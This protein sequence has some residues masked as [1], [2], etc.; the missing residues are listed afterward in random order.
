MSCQHCGERGSQ[1]LGPLQFLGCDAPECVEQLG[2]R[3]SHYG[4]EHYLIHEATPFGR[5]LS[6]RPVFVAKRDGEWLVVGRK[7]AHALAPTLVTV[8]QDPSRKRRPGVEDDA[9]D[10]P[11]SPRHKGTAE[12]A[13]AAAPYVPL[14]ARRKHPVGTPAA[15]PR[16]PLSARRKYRPLKGHGPLTQGARESFLAVPKDV[17]AITFP[18][19]SREHREAMDTSTASVASRPD[20]QAAE[21]RKT[22]T[23]REACALYVSPIDAIKVQALRM[24]WPNIA[25]SALG[26]MLLMDE[27]VWPPDRLIDSTWTDA[28]ERLEAEVGDLGPAVVTFADGTTEVP[29]SLSALLQCGMWRRNPALILDAAEM[30]THL[31]NVPYESPETYDFLGFLLDQSR[32]WGASPP[33]GLPNLVRRPG[34]FAPSLEERGVDLARINQ[35]DGRSVAHTLALLVTNRV[36]NAQSALQ[37]LQ[38]TAQ[39]DLTGVVQLDPT[40]FDS[41]I[42][43][44]IHWPVDMFASVLRIMRERGVFRGVLVH[45]L[46]QEG[47]TVLHLRVDSLAELRGYAQ[48]LIDRAQEIAPVTFGSDVPVVVQNWRGEPPLLALAAADAI[49]Q[50]REIIGRGHVNAWRPLAVDGDGYT[51]GTF[52]A[53]YRFRDLRVRDRYERTKAL[54]NLLVALGG[55]VDAP[56]SPKMLSK[57]MAGVER[58][59]QDERREILRVLKVFWSVMPSASP[60]PPGAYAELWEPMIKLAF[61]EGDFA[62]VGTELLRAFPVVATTFHR[63]LYA[64]IDGNLA[65]Y[66]VRHTL[67]RQ[68]PKDARALIREVARLAPATM[69]EEDKARKQPWEYD[70]KDK[71]GVQLFTEEGWVSMGVDPPA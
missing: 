17:W 8:G 57:L 59:R 63:P 25:R 38:F 32:V 2:T 43:L 26:F 68:R 10:E 15:A 20:V 44:T 54:G 67:A 9:E 58:E 46:D 35:I 71:N 65:H 51:V 61:G 62:W 52:L 33:I 29:M 34:S 27:V 5:A 70:T 41:L 11:E 13:A 37:Q 60:T 64:R 53:D 66:T 36:L 7:L 47:N 23:L 6:A 50:V 22:L 69:N 16:T 39:L 48:E 18:L 4:P 24:A 14:S 42:S 45:P 31:A 3:V 30:E 56:S 49:D 21:F 28:V 1:R 40:R 55:Q 12:A 19:L